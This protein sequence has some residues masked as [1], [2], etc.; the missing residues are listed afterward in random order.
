MTIETEKQLQGLK[1]AGSLVADCLK[2]MLASIEE[3]MTTKELDDIGR[4]FLESRGA[5]S[6]PELTYQF[7]GATCICLEHEAAHGLPSVKK[8]ISRGMLVNIDVSAEL[9]GYFADTGASY[10]YGSDNRQLQELCRSTQKALK[11]AVQAVRSGAPLNVIGKSIEKEAKKTPFTIIRNLCSHGVGG[12]LHEEPDSITGYY[13]RRDR[14]MITKGLVF[15]I[16][17]FL[18][19]GSFYAHEGHDGWTLYNEP[20]FYSA[21]YEHTL[22]ATP[23]GA[24]IITMPTDGKPF[25][26]NLR[27]S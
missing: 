3:G 26:P 24:I 1:K 10:L 22:V 17:P 9:N 12:A 18:S 27:A 15:T 14:R 20:G 7:P 21:Q 8:K 13:N 23:K 25:V 11:A 5:R 16:E 6:A 19:T 4:N 2:H